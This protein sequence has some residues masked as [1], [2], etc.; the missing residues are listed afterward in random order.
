MWSA[1]ITRCAVSPDVTGCTRATQRSIRSTA[2]TNA[3][4]GATQGDRCGLRAVDAAVL[5]ASSPTPAHRSLST[6]ATNVIQEPDAAPDQSALA[7]LSRQSAPRR[8]AEVFGAFAGEPTTTSPPDQR[9][10]IGTTRG[11]SS[12]HTH[13][14][15]AGMAD[16]KSSF[17]TGSSNTDALPVAIRA[18][19]IPLLE[20]IEGSTSA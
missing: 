12:G 10:Q 3:A 16:E 2:A 14:T 17:A 19:C 1:P 20:K 7:K 15:Y 4:A 13:A 18:P 5:V 11:V 6:H 8:S 9:D